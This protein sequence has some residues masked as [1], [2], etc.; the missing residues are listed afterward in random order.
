MNMR[1]LFPLLLIAASTIG[2]AQ[3]PETPEPGDALPSISVGAIG[4]GTMNIH[5]GDFS[6]YDGILECGTFDDA[7]TLG[8]GLGYVVDLPFTS[9]FSLSGR[10]YYW[11]G[12][13][14]FVTPNPT[15]IR[16]AV[17]DKT[18][19]PLQTEH[20]LETALDYGMIDLLLRY[21]FASPFYIA[22]GP[23]AGFAARAA[24][25]QEE[26][27]LSPDG[28]TFLNGLPTRKIIAGNF[29]EQ[30]TLNTS[31]VVR[32]GATGMIGAEIPI[33]DR[34]ALTPEAGFTFGL[35]GVLSSFDWTVH[36]VRAG[37]GVAYRLTGS[38][39][40]DT[41]L[42]AGPD[43][44]APKPVVAVRAFNRQNGIDLNYADVVIA[45]ERSTDLVPLLPYIFFESN[46]SSIPDRYHR[47][48]P[49]SSA[50]FNEEN[51]RD[52]TIG[53]Y[54]DLL[55]IVGSRMRRYPESTITLIGC[56]E[57]LDD[58]SSTDAL[59]LARANMVRDY[60]TSSWGIAT[61]RIG[62]KSRA[63]PREVSNRSVAD[64]RQENRRVEIE[65]GDH[66][67]VAPVVTRSG[68]IDIDPDALVIVPE[69]Q[70]AES[71]ASWK[72]RVA[73]EEG[74]ELFARQ[75][76]GVPESRFSWILA[77]ADAHRLVPA[78]AAASTL[79]ARLVAIT[80]E[81]EELVA[82]REIPVRRTFSSRLASG[83]VVRDSLVERYSLIFFDF[84]APQIT[85]F[86]SFAVE[87]IRNRMRTSSKVHITGLTDRIGDDAH[88]MDLSKRRAEKTSEKIRDRI[89]PEVTTTEGGGEKEVYNND[90]PEGRMYNR[91][92]M[93]EIVT[94]IEGQP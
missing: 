35:T 37:I 22:I 41:V 7:Q 81:G 18:L 75:G 38:S 93:V 67:L 47:L 4:W 3:A 30:G 77:N 88:N 36:A 54:H 94:P 40:P 76:S 56:R 51:L 86:N 65:T 16:I 8:W 53:V 52:S 83:E 71:I 21:R 43:V 84:D 20:A 60:L 89:T 61:E 26:R 50:S 27:I 45:E 73:S 14:D 39:H 91:T 15:P 69:L 62:V 63:L 79:R 66:R 72:M 24:Y 68:G 82:E 9:R 19:V 11:K 29:D 17:D 64:G 78:G 58:T 44:R 74:V 31:R 33:A 6:T 13:G 70:F 42:L 48:T 85:E 49:V 10:V 5:R 46:E 90:L 12:D 2:F 80:T 28:A 32:V 25:E 87:A 92:V 34:V 23:S 1:Y 57:P 55:N 59:S